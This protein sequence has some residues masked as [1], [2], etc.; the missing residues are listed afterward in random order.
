MHQVRSM[1][2][3]GDNLNIPD[4]V[5][6]PTAELLLV[7]TQTALSTPKAKYM[8]LDIANFYLNLCGHPEQYLHAYHHA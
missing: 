4:D 2:V 8:T 3:E 1:A 6:M 7:K 5:C